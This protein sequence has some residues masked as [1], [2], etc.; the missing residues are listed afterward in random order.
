MIYYF[1]IFLILDRNKLSIVRWKIMFNIV[2]LCMPRISMTDGHGWQH[3]P[4]KSGCLPREQEFRNVEFHLTP[5]NICFFARH[6]K[7]FDA[8]PRLQACHDDFSLWPR[9]WLWER[10]D[11]FHPRPRGWCAHPIFYAAVLEIYYS[12]IY[13]RRCNL[14]YWYRHVHWNAL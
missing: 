5:L 10:L 12:Y 1:S 2:M 4:K 7:R 11:D 6:S 8:S 14:R 13:V 9:G 3:I